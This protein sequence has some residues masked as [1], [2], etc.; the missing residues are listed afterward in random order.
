M[1]SDDKLRDKKNYNMILTEK[2]Q[3]CHQHCHQEKFKNANIL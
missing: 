3:H 2:L 1:A